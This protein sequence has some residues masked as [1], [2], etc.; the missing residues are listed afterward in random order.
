M[1]VELQLFWIDFINGII[2]RFEENVVSSRKHGETRWH[3]VICHTS[4]LFIQV[5]HLF[6]ST[7]N[8][9]NYTNYMQFQ[10]YLY[11]SR[12]WTTNGTNWPSSQ[13]SFHSPASLLFRECP[14]RIEKFVSFVQFVVIKKDGKVQLSNLNSQFSIL[15][16]SRIPLRAF[17]RGRGVRVPA[18]PREDYVWRLTSGSA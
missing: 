3:W 4:Y 12:W 8:Y 2:W 13:N 10:R 1:S 5:S 16:T 9:A 17:H 18:W 11:Y 6:S 14:L 15:H 7:T